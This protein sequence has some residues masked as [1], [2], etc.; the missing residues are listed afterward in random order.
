MRE[1]SE[2]RKRQCAKL[3]EL[4]KKVIRESFDKFKF[5]ELGLTCGHSMGRFKLWTV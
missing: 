4:S 2:K 1:M 3:V 5:K